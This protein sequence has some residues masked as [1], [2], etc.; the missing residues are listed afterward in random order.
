MNALSKF[1]YK[2]RV[3]RASIEFPRMPRVDVVRLQMVKRGLMDVISSSLLDPFSVYTLNLLNNIENYLS[4][5]ENKVLCYLLQS[6]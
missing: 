4:P 3:Y 1:V 6:I 2:S 5:M